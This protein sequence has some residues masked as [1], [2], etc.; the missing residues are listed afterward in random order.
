VFRQPTIEQLDAFIAPTFAARVEGARY[1]HDRLREII[2]EVDA[3]VIVE[4]NVVGFPAIVA[5]GRPWVRVVSCHPAEIKDPN[6]PPP[7]SGDTYG[8]A[9]QELRDGVDGLLADDALRTRLADGAAV[10][11]AAPGT[12][13]AADLIEQLVREPAA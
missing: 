3:D 5:S 7:F 4:D 12:V 13:R 2:E 6:I 8:H 1:V 10:L 9:P 11:Q